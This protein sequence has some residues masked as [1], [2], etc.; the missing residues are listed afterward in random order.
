MKI[1]KNEYYSICDHDVIDI[2][3]SGETEEEAIADYKEHLKIH[4]TKLVK[5]LAKI[6]EIEKE[7]ESL[8]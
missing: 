8:K 4:K 3:G 6:E 7:I 5:Q 2:W 1:E